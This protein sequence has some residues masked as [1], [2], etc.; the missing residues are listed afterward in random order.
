MGE[1]HPCLSHLTLEPAQSTG[2]VH[3]GYTLAQTQPVPTGHDGWPLML[4][5]A[6]PGDAAPFPS[7]GATPIGATAA[8]RTPHAPWPDAADDATHD[9]AP[10]YGTGNTAGT[11]T[12]TLWGAWGS[13]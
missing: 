9:S 11:C 2:A 6:S 4:L 12:P 1:L 13:G 3:G 7:D 10:A 5:D 8:C